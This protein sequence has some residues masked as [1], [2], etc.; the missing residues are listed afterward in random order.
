MFKNELIFLSPWN[1][2]N[3]TTNIFV[4]ILSTNTQPF[5]PESLKLFQVIF[6]SLYLV[7]K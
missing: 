7:L 1:Y 6:P 5:M 2:N 4:C 3:T